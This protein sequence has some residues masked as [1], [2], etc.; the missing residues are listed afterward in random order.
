MLRFEDGR[1]VTAADVEALAGW[2]PGSNEDKEIAYRPARVLLQDFTGVP[3]VVDLAAMRDAI[4]EMGGEAGARSIRCSRSRS[5]SI[6]PCKSTRSARPM[7]FENNAK[8][9]FERNGERYGFLKWGQNAL[10]D[11]RAVPPDTGIVHQVNI[12][13]LARIVFGAGGAG[14][15]HPAE[16]IAAGLSR[17]RWSAPTRTRRWPTASACSR[18][19]SAAS[20]PRPRCSVS[21]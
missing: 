13:Y 14:E 8:L 1:S 19:A 16:A 17:I 9:E 2:K 11:F 5:S 20:K 3:C 18:G 21:R 6:T 7:R 4:A 15:A 10:A 12:E